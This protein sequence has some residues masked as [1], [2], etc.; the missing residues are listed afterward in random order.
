MLYYLPNPLDPAQVIAIEHRSTGYRPQRTDKHLDQSWCDGMNA[1]TGITREE[2]I[3]AFYCSFTED[4]P[5]WA[6]LDYLVPTRHEPG[7]I[8]P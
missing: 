2:A 6:R 1:H 5:A 3:L 4:N 8:N 7:Y